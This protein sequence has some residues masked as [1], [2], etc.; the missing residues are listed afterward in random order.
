MAGY[1]YHL[2]GVSGGIL[3][4]SM[5]DLPLEF[6]KLEQPARLLR[7]LALDRD[8]MKA[9]ALSLMHIFSRTRVAVSVRLGRHQEGGEAHG[10]GDGG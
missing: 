9:F 2:D 6:S 4:V 7:G 1:G 10:A 8:D 5:A 3:P